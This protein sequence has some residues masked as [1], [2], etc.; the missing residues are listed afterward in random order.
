MPFKASRRCAKALA[1]AAFATALGF[2]ASAAQ[3][4]TASLQTQVNIL[5]PLSMVKTADMDF[6]NVV[7][8]S[9]AGTV[10]LT[11][12]TTAS[13]TTTGGLIRSGTCRAATFMG[14]GATNQ[15]VRI[16][17][18][19]STVTL[20]NGLGQT[21]TVTNRTADGTPALNYLSG[22]VNSNGNVRYRIVSASGIFDYRVGG[23]L[24]V[25]ANQAMGTYSGTFNVTLEYD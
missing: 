21:M 3:A 2:T 18:N 17:F 23:T 8:P 10:V 22:N 7:R 1:A 11:P 5:T 4:G 20:A 9:A 24:N 19:G 13:C 12:T 25:A 14:F 16:R 6:G 15:I